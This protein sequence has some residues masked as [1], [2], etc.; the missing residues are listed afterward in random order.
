[1]F[2]DKQV[3]SVHMHCPLPIPTDK[4]CIILLISARQLYRVLA[5]NKVK[6]NIQTGHIIMV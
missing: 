2:V 5:F 6:Q 3:C 4:I 1:M